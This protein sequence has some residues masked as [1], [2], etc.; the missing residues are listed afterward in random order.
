MFS[1]NHPLLG[2]FSNP[3]WQAAQSWFAQHR[4]AVFWIG[5]GSGLICVLSMATVPWIV[6]RLPEDY[7]V[8]LE[9]PVAVGNP[10][11]LRSLLRNLGGWMLLVLGVLLVPL[12]GPGMLVILLA[13]GLVDFPGKRPLVGSILRRPA[14]LRSINWLRRRARRPEMVLLNRVDDEP[15]RFSPVPPDPTGQA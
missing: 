2:R 5:A 6:A 8:R 3:I 11:W 13:L 14:V 1:S 15:A 4:E 10:H 7:L 12:P 9:A